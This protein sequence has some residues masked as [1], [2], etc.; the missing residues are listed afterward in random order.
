MNNL[1][2]LAEGESVVLDGQASRIPDPPPSSRCQYCGQAIVPM[3]MSLPGGRQSWWMPVCR[4]REQAEKK[5]EREERIAAALQ[6]TYQRFQ[7][8][9]PGRKF[10]HAALAG[11]HPDPRQPSQANAL[12]FLH[13]YIGHFQE[14]SETGKGIFLHGPPGT[15]KSYLAA[16]LANEL[17]QRGRLALFIPVARLLDRLRASY[18]RHEQES[19]FDL[20]QMLL[21]ADLLVLDDLGAGQ[22]TEWTRDKIFQLVDG[23]YL[24]QAPLVVTSNSSHAQLER[25]LGLRTMDRIV[26]MCRP[27]AVLGPSYRRK[28]WQETQVRERARP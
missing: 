7:L 10:G 19:L 23:R 2:S 4:C 22:T 28:G 5:R 18:S 27:L 26:E 15:G 13:G 1:V 14:T 9:G 24:A 21:R 6:E 12:S 20:L 11:Y 3:L 25:D 8:E 16:A 17:V